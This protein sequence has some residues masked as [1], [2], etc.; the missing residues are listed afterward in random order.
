M[1][2]V[3]TFEDARRRYRGRVALVPTMGY[4]HEG[5]LALMTAARAAADT[6]VVSHFV[7][8]LQF[9][10]PAD[11]DRYPRDLDRDLELALPVGIDLMFVPSQIEMYPTEPLTRVK[12][13]GVSEGL[14]GRYR[15]GHFEGVATVVAKLFAGLQP[16]VAHFGRKDAQQLAV[17]RRMAA[18]LSF[19]VSVLGQPTIRESDGLALSS[20]NVFIP[21]EDRAGALLLSQ[22][23]FAAARLAETGESRADRL[24]EE[25][26][27]VAG[28]LN[29]EYVEL[30]SQDSADPIEALDRPSFLAAAIRVGPVRLIDNVAFDLVAGQVMADLGI[31]LEHPSVLYR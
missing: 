30:A 1:E 31:R 9:D 3:R 7:N 14:E 29:V 2:V 15:P 6:V 20:R 18:D 12:V 11:L 4:F 5:H 21:P 16:Q 22:G 26:C 17:I 27:S 19:P 23:L 13:S 25:F 24:K 28:G 10:D 8:R